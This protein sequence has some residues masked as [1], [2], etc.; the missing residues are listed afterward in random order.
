MN[1]PDWKN[2][3]LRGRETTRPSE[4]N[5]RFRPSKPKNGVTDS[6]LTTVR[7]L[8]RHI[9]GIQVALRRPLSG[10][11]DRPAEDNTPQE[12]GILEERF[13]DLQCVGIIASGRQL[14]E[15]T[16]VFRIFLTK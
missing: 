5:G 6:L 7:S 10:S 14:T 12:K 2:V 9:R 3:P 15:T 4:Q 1:R 13:L 11:V 16:A 8:L